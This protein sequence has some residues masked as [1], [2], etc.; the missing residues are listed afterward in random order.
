MKEPYRH[1]IKYT[2]SRHLQWHLTVLSH[3]YDQGRVIAL[4]QAGNNV[5]VSHSPTVLVPFKGSFSSS[6]AAGTETES[7]F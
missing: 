1:H 4:V 5:K 7:C 3:S 6:L 2:V